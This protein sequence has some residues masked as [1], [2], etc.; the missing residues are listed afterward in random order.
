MERKEE[1]ED[2]KTTAGDGVQLTSSQQDHHQ[3]FHHHHYHSNEEKA[4]AIVAEEGTT[5]QPT[6]VFAWPASRQHPTQY[7]ST[8]TEY[9]N[10]H[11]DWHARASSFFLVLLQQISYRNLASQKSSSVP[12]D[13][14]ESRGT[15]PAEHISLSCMC[16]CVCGFSTVA[17]TSLSRG[18][19]DH[20]Y[21]QT[22]L[23]SLFSFL[24]DSLD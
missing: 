20:H 7:N 5:R 24:F 6:P 16:V 17:I 10:R 8:T 4:A 21:H 9:W 18:P 14:T 23:T 12:F 11:S 3:H 15:Q 19:A 2:V 22:P 1:E 13:L